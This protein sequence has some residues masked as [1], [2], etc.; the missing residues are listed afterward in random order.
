MNR[1]RLGAALGGVAAWVLVA[2]LALFAV[3]QWDPF[4]GFFP[5]AAAVLGAWAIGEWM[6]SRET[7]DATK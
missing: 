3:D 6:S 5:V 4:W 1:T 7:H 2:A